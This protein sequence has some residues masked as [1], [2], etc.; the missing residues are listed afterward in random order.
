M[1]NLFGL[2]VLAIMRIGF[3]N[4]KC[5]NP[6]MI[7]FTNSKGNMIYA[8]KNESS[9]EMS[10]YKATA[11]CLYLEIEKDNQLKDVISIIALKLNLT[12]LK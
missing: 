6:D 9:I 7:G 2:T 5:G 12:R 4:N 11:R 3:V 8:K 10:V 1:E